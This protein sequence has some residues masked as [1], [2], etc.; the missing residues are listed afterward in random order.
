MDVLNYTQIAANIATVVG[1]AMGGPMLL[2]AVLNYLEGL[3]S[4]TRKKNGVSLS[5][6]NARFF[7]KFGPT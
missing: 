3:D 6:Y 2:L 5:S 7:E 4:P 1:V